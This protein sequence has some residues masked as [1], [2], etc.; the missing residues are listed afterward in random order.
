MSCKSC[1][2]QTKCNTCNSCDDKPKSVC[3]KYSLACRNP[4]DVGSV[5]SSDNGEYIILLS[6]KTHLDAD[7]DK[8]GLPDWIGIG[9]R[10]CKKYTSISTNHLIKLWNTKRT[11]DS[12]C[13]RNTTFKSINP[14]GFITYKLVDDQSKSTAIKILNASLETDG[15][16]NSL[17]LVVKLLS[18]ES[19]HKDLNAL[20]THLFNVNLF[21]DGLRLD[22]K[23]Q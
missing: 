7:Q 17:K 1:L 4:F 15:L 16:G 10:P 11:C 13:L 2:K 12:A 18:N 23:H 14:N 5:T 22:T 9:E 6:G 21:I 20:P 3:K 8:D 19:H